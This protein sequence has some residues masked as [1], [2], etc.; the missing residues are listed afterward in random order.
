MSLI[1]FKKISKAFLS[2]PQPEVLAIKG[3][4][5]IGKTRAWSDIVKSKSQ[6][7]ALP[8]YSYVS[9][10]GVSTMEEVKRLIFTT[11]IPVEKIGE[12]WTFSAWRSYAGSVFGL[13]KVVAGKAEDVYGV[14]AV[15]EVPL[16]IVEKLVT[17]WVQDTV[18][19]FDDLERS[20]VPIEEILGLISDLKENHDCKIILIFNAEKLAET[21]QDK[22]RQYREKAIDKEIHF[23]PKPEE[24]M[25]IALPKKM[26]FR[27]AVERCV[28]KLDIHNIRILKKIVE[29][30]NLI[31]EDIK[32]FHPS[33]IENAIPSIV[34]LTWAFYDSTEEN[35]GIKDILSS[36]AFRWKEKK[37]LSKEEAELL[38]KLRAYGF[39]NV[40]DLDRSIA[41]V[42]QDGYVE[43]SNIKEVAAQFDKRAKN[44][45]LLADFQNAWSQFY[46]SFE[47]NQDKV[48][49]RLIAGAKK[50]ISLISI[51][52]IDATVGLL[53]EL[54]EEEKAN[55]LIEIYLNDPGNEE[56]AFDLKTSSFVFPINDERLK[57]RLKEVHDS[58]LRP[59]SLREVAVELAGKN[60][61]STEEMEV[62]RGSSVDDF[63]SLFTTSQ[64]KNL[65]ELI[66]A[67][68]QFK[69][70]A[71]SGDLAI[72]PLEALRKIGNQSKIN[73][74]RV[75]KYGVF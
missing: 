50:A 64:S 51:N 63:Y 58:M 67:C 61:F 15:A 4:W 26:L 65:P 56:L 21:D 53:R 14:P 40:D 5:G 52:D 8:K 16:G 48:A 70:Y 54:G 23:Q 44:S 32:N 49:S 17:Q 11:T 39:V 7:W 20:T 38:G 9:L 69:N 57:S 47:D 45:E 43:E 27:D 66:Q 42:I 31:N 68:I 22:Y 62:L 37:D 55:E 29:M 19:C 72:N 60:G 41:Q 36:D 10:F 28:L 2:N 46:G 13:A 6:K 75:K 33:V 30:V 12:K 71:N 34:L 3:S 74:L 25:E 35:Y 24:I 59:K 1:I 73:S 18:V